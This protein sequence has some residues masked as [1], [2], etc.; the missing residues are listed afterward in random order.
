VTSAG[1]LARPDEIRFTYAL[2]KTRS[3][4]VM[5]RLPRDIIAGREF[6]G[7]TT[8]LEDYTVLAKFREAEE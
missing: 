3:G 1:A 4:T 7:A 6:A 8:M 5:R 2:P